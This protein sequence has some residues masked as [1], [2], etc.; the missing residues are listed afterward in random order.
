MGFWTLLTHQNWTVEWLRRKND[1]NG[2]RNWCAIAMN[3]KVIWELALLS[4]RFVSKFL[5]ETTDRGTIEKGGAHAIFNTYNFGF[6][7]NSA[8]FLEGKSLRGA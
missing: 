6:C 4:F 2:G 7:G 3:L 8:W 1:S 5:Y